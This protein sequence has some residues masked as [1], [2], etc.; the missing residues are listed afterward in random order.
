MVALVSYLSSV[1]RG[2]LT[3]LRGGRDQAAQFGLFELAEA[4]RWA[5]ISQN[6]NDR[7]AR[8]AHSD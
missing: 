2:G 4:I 3:R 6:F 5:C 8:E 1:F 7:R